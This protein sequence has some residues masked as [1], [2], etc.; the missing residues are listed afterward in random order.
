MPNDYGLPTGPLSAYLGVR[1]A[2][3]RAGL[4]D[5]QNLSGQ[6]GLLQHIEALKQQ[7]ALREAL[8]SGNPALLAQTPGGIGILKQLQDM[9]HSAQQSKLYEAQTTKLGNDA[10]AGAN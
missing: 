1:D 8:A 9:S 10:I 4:L 5:T 2:N 3:Q 7:Q 6:V